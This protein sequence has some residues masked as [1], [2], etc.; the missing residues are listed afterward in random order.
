M[1]SVDLVSLIPA[2]LLIGF[3]VGAWLWRREGGCILPAVVPMITANEVSQRIAEV[4]RNIV[5]SIFE[6]AQPILTAIGVAQILLGLLLAAGFR[7]EFLGYRLV[8]GGIITLI[9]TYIVAPLLLS[10]I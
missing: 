1:N 9:F 3:F 8:I 10:F 7:Q 2:A 4:V 5:L 6:I